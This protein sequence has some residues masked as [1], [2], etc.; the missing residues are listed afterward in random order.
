MSSQEIVLST[1]KSFVATFASAFILHLFLHCLAQ[2]PLPLQA[3]P[4]FHSPVAD[5]LQVT[6]RVSPSRLPKISS[7]PPMTIM[8]SSV[9]VLLKMATGPSRPSKLSLTSK[10]PLNLSQLMLRMIYPS[11]Q[12]PNTSNGSTV[13]LTALSTTT[14]VSPTTPRAL[15]SRYLRT[16]FLRPSALSS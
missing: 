4:P 1:S 14:A 11:K 6:T 10:V 16:W 12:L 15:L 2:G 7:S 5:T 3:T 8:F 13:T 9:A